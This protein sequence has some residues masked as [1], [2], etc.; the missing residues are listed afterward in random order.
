MKKKHKN[1]PEKPKVNS[2][3]QGFDIRINS[4]GEIE[5]NFSIDEL[6]QFLN[7]HVV[8]KKLK[9]RDDLDVLHESEDSDT[10][11]GSSDDGG[12]DSGGGD[13]D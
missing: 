10:D 5:S 11:S 1:E 4:S 12:G 8:D 2:K 9:D 7:Q 3:L 13:G 6:N